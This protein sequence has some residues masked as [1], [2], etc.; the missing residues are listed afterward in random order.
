M[1]FLSLT[2]VIDMERRLFDALHRQELT[3]DFRLIHVMGRLQFDVDICQRRVIIIM[4]MERFDM[5]MMV[6][7]ER[8]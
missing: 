5:H 1:I 6:V 4:R 8:R 2:A 3:D 7:D